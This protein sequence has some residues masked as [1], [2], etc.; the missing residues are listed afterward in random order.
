MLPLPAEPVQNVSPTSVRQISRDALVYGVGALIARIA[1][2]LFLPVYG[3]YLS[4]ADYGQLQ[5]LELV[6]DVASI[7]AAAGTASALMR[8][9]VTT[10]DPIE[11]QRTVVSALYLMLAL[12]GAMALVLILAAGPIAQLALNDAG[13]ADLVRIAAVTFTLQGTSAVPLLLMQAERRAGTYM[14]ASV[15][16]L[17]LNLA[18][19]IFLVVVLG[20]G[21]PG[22]LLANLVTAVAMGV[23]LTGR[24][25][26]RFGIAASRKAMRQL[27]SFSFPLQV[28]TAG[29]FILQFGDRLVLT[30]THGLAAVGIYG[31]AYQFG[32]LYVS[33]AAIPFMR[34]WQPVRLAQSHLPP[35]ERDRGYNHAF[36]LL[37]LSLVTIAVGIS[38]FARP[39]LTVLVA[40]SFHASTNLVSLILL[41]FIFQTW[42]DVAQLG[43]EV[44]VQTRRISAATWIAT[45]I[46]VVLYLA[47]I[48]RFGG[49]G[50]ALATALGFCARFVIM[51][52]FAQRTLPVAWAW[53]SAIRLVAIG[54][55][56]CIA[57]IFVPQGG[58]LQSFALATL[59]A[60]MFFVALWRFEL[61]EQ[62]RG[63]ILAIARSPREGWRSLLET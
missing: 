19:A 34:A 9:Y 23:A 37:N 40:P 31:L 32:F 50:A 44:A 35:E 59:F 54:S 55:V 2:F 61:S 52:R 18:L 63:Q 25:F 49:L 17:V 62:E 11:R 15:V 20:W 22:V 27:R 33:F 39:V 14:A 51:D 26:V 13:H 29:T 43:L 7:A 24:L 46:T 56:P 28:A 21:V 53:G 5:M 60:L 8:F 3:R 6:V 42:T 38:L 12:N 57:W 30:R 1:S 16:K 58:A 36:R 47:L 45:A 41:A 10:T 48:P 4:P